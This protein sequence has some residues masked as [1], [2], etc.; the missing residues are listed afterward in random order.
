MREFN[1]GATRDT[2][3]GK[4]DYEA[5]FSPQVLKRRAEYMHNHRIQA[6]GT[7]R[8][9][10]N[11]QKGIP[12]EEY[13]KSGFRHFMDWWTEH[14]DM[15]LAEGKDD[16]SVMEEAI[17]ALMFNCEGYLHELLKGE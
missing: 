4:L 11:W 6:D 15:L 13:M 10:D 9:G 12:L 8:A 14:R 2:A 16:V 5:F 1:T 7:L 3:D 17:C